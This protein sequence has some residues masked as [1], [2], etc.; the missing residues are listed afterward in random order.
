VVIGRSR[1]V[2]K[3]NRSEEGANDL[4]PWSYAERIDLRVH[5]ERS[6]C[7]TSVQK[8]Y[9][10]QP[11]REE[12]V[13]VERRR[14]RSNRFFSPEDCARSL[15][16]RGQTW[17]SGFN[18]TFFF[19]CCK[20]NALLRLIVP[21]FWLLAESNRRRGIPQSLIFQDE[22]HLRERQATLP[23]DSATTNPKSDPA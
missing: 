18:L 3:S 4:L 22:L 6:L 1:I 23:A 14:N 9:I 21:V 8:I 13:R 10:D 17:D 12:F 15:L 19:D 7:A 2:L 5:I 11:T 20:G 16:R